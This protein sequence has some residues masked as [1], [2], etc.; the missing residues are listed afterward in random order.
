[1]GAWLEAYGALEESVA[2]VLAT[3]DTAHAAALAERGA[4]ALWRRSEIGPLRRWLHAL[5]DEVIQARPWLQVYQIWARFVSGQVEANE[6]LLDEVER[7]LPPD[8]PEAEHW[9]LTGSLVAL[10]AF[11]AHAFH[12]S[13]RAERLAREALALLPDSELSW[14]SL[15]AICLGHAPH[16]RGDL[17][18]AYHAYEEAAATGEKAHD[19]YMV[20][21][22]TLGTTNI[23]EEQ[24]EP[25]AA[26]AT[27]LH[28]LDR[29]TRRGRPALPALGYV[30]ASLGTLAC[31]WDQREE[32]EERIR[33]AWDYGKRGGIT[34]LEV[35]APL[36]LASIYRI[37]GEY[38][39]A[40]EMVAEA[41]RPAP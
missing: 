34:D 12:D 11:L 40:L 41:E 8:L 14:R 39:R 22:G 9:A 38:T 27:L 16:A 29:F 13:A 26:Y 10:R 15:T 17:A 4:A 20:L 5:P 35:N 36:H 30:E 2:H 1:A 25:R 7:S 6:R 23:Q 28:M 3:G 21:I 33:R 37:R 18:A 24:A 19:D 31:E 32:A